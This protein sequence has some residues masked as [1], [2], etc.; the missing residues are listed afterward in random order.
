M[1]PNEFGKFFKKKFKILICRHGQSIWNK[2][3]KFTGWCDIP[4]TMKGKKDS[5][6]MGST[7]I[8][9]NL[10]P[11]KIYTSD[12]IRTIETADVIRKTLRNEE[13]PIISNWRLSEKHYGG[14]EGVPRKV[15][16][17][18]YGGFYLNKL[19]KDY[20][21]KPPS[22]VDLYEYRDE[23]IERY[24][25]DKSNNFMKEIYIEKNDLNNLGENLIM[26]NERLKYYFNNII[27]PNFEENDL[28]LLITH[29][30][31]IRILIQQFKEMPEEEFYEFDPS[32]KSIYYISFDEDKVNVI[33]L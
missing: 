16:G 6:H 11:N 13:I 26:V 23:I 17:D 14:C 7:L 31:P 19:R 5:F 20:M 32:N 2:E 29:K 24:L 12:S 1:I 9:N 33:E 15:I 25:K 21:I 8:K 22:Q 10:I 28:P 3:Q 18:R 4:I 30:H 27:L